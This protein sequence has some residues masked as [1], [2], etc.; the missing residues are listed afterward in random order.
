MVG[1]KKIH[2]FLI[3]VFLLMAGFLAATARSDA[4]ANP[5]PD[6]YSFNMENPYGTPEPQLT[7]RQQALAGKLAKGFVKAIKSESSTWW[8]CGEKTPEEKWDERAL[9]MA[10]HLIQAFVEYDPNRNVTKLWGAWGVIWSESRGN[11]CAVGPNPRKYAVKSGILG[12]PKNPHLWT[13]QE[14]RDVLSDPRWKG[15]RADISIGQVVWRTYARLPCQEG[16]KNCKRES[17]RWVRVPTLDEMLSIEGGAR[18]TAYGM[19]LRQSWSKLGSKLPWFHWP[20]MRADYTYGKKI[21]G[22]VARMGGPY[23]RVLGH[24]IP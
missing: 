13:E 18:V 16:E 21:A 8:E 17:R 6:L 22:V 20:G 11:R 10:Q 14:V 15:R 24:K 19:V 9:E 1:T 4:P 23:K 3:M 2:W 5:S 7:E 12:G